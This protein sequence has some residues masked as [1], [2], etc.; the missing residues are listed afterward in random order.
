MPLELLV[1]EGRACPHQV[2]HRVLGRHSECEPDVAELEV[3]VNEDDVRVAL[4]ERDGEVRRDERL[5]GASLRPQDGDERRI[6]L[7]RD[8]EALAARDDFL[9][10]EG[11]LFR[12]L[13]ERDHVLRAR[14]ECL[15][16]EAVRRRLAHDDDRPVGPVFHGVVHHRRHGVVVAVAGNDDDVS[17]LLEER[18]PVFEVFHIAD[19]LER[20]LVPERLL[21]E[22]RVGVLGEHDEDADRVGHLS[23]PSGC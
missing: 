7:A 15:P 17:G 4:G 16:Q 12:R 3:E 1:V 11:D 19:H 9:E 8:G 13:R 23:V 10:R 18:A 5:P 14:L 6:R 21:D 20:R 2:V 22:P